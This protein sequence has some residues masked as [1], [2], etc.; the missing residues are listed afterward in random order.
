[1]RVDGAEVVVSAPRQRAVLAYL[2]TAEGE[3]VPA[4]RILEAVW[5]DD[6]PTTGVRAVA[7]HISRLRSLLDP[8]GDRTTT[9][10]ETSAAGYR[11]AFDRHAIDVHRFHDSVDRARHQLPHDPGGCERRLVDALS[12]WRGRP[13]ADLGDEPF[14]DD[15]A[16]R[17]ERARSSARRML[18]EARMA[19][20]RHQDVI[21]DL[22]ELVEAEPLDEGH[23]RLLMIALQRS[24]R[25]ADGLRAYGELRIRLGDELGIEPSPD[26]QQLQQ[27]LLVGEAVPG[28]R[29]AVRQSP[30]SSLPVAMTSFVGRVEEVE[31]LGALIGANRV[32]TLCGFGGLGKTRLAQE[33]AR[34]VEGGDAGGVHFVDLTLATT[35]EDL[36]D[37]VLTAIGGS[38]TDE[39]DSVSDLLRT[40]T[41]LDLLLVLDNCEHLIDGVADLVARMCRAIPGV[42]VLATSREPLGLDGET[43]WSM[44]PL[45][46]SDAVQLFR[47]RAGTAAPDPAV[48]GADEEIHRLCGRLDG[49]PLAIE[50]AA[51][52]L[53]VMTVG[54]IEQHMDQ[55]L[56]ALT[57]HRGDAR[58]RSLHAVIASSCGLR[59]DGDQML[60]A[61]LSVCPS[62][63]DLD[64]AFALAGSDAGHHNE[65]VDGLRRL[66][67]C[68]LVVVT[69]DAD[70]RR[71][72]ILAAVRGVAQ[73][74]IDPAELDAARQRHAEHYAAVAGT[75]FDLWI[76]D[77]E[78]MLRLGDLEVGNLR[79]AM[80][81]AF[82]HDRVQ[83]GLAITRG[84]RMYFWSRRMHRE[85]IRWMLTGIE[86]GIADGPD[87][88]SNGAGDAVEVLDAAAIVLIEAHNVGDVRA[89]EAALPLVER[90]LDRIEEPMLRGNLLSAMGAHLQASDPVGAERLH[91]DAFTL[92]R[93]SGVRALPSLA[94][95]IEASWRSG[96]LDGSDVLASLRQIT[97]ALDVVPALATKIEAGVAARR[98][99]WDEVLRVAQLMP[100][101][102]AATEVSVQLLVA[103]ALI[104]LGRHGEAAAC[105]EALEADT[106]GSQRVLSDLLWASLEIGRDRDLGRVVDRLGDLVP[107]VHDDEPVPAVAMPVAALLGTAAVGLGDVESAA[108]LFGFADS[109]QHR[110]GT[111]LRPGDRVAVDD[112][113]ERCRT[114][115]GAEQFD[116]LRAHGAATPWSALPSPTVR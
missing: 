3:A 105:L 25:P 66:A 76:Q 86:L 64:A 58:R 102:D 111:R 51:S 46:E 115:L 98:G 70:T 41:G 59:A 8:R 10:I 22:F 7:F 74:R 103:E 72:R 18:A 1:M 87:G 36:A 82:E 37:T 78:A 53:A 16:R 69:D 109:E 15:E 67:D 107:V 27:Q 6:L 96:I 104:G 116:R 33:A 30:R 32:V 11:L 34:F 81:W 4:D 60:L 14:V 68:S 89:I 75:V 106:D 61:R 63:F 110:L 2:A 23:V 77:Q 26:L 85:N 100:P 62:G 40:L 21:V 5:G 31:A 101:P 50:L 91:A 97:E 54:Q 90:G 17:L 73:E 88:R 65:V 45:V 13:F 19:L 79:A 44:R 49:I 20:G 108:A 84:A 112:A 92:R 80:A 99:D 42:R 29:H 43:V 52:Q 94:N 114:A 56:D 39:H 83:L 12:W 95:R 71:F 38:A 57:A 35:P 9:L 93:P 28:E 47:A 48:E 55:Q 113:V 24:N